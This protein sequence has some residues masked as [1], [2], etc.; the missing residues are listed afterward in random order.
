MGLLVISYLVLIFHPDFQYQRSDIWFAISSFK[1]KGAILY[2]SLSITSSSSI[3]VFDP[4]SSVA[5]RKYSY[6]NQNHMMWFH[7]K[8]PVNAW[9]LVPL[10]VSFSN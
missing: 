3:T 1:K 10:C 4:L 6:Y 8:G 2:F 9:G 7:K 5:G